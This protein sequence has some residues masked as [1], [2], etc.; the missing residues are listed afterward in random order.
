[1][2]RYFCTV[3]T[4]LLLALVSTGSAAAGLPLLGDTQ[5]GSQ[6]TSF[7]DQ[8]VGEQKNDADVN[9]A[10][11][12]G[13]V[14]VSPAIAIFGDA[15]TWNAQGNGNT[16]Q[17]DVD[18]SNT[19]TQTQDSR[20][21]QDL[22]QNGPSGS[23]HCCGGQSQTGEQATDFGDQTVDKQK[24]T[25]TSTRHRERERERLPGNRGVR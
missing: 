14:N 11:G 7:G 17:A 5:Q 20:Q 19:A 1:M 25:P 23:G 24:T 9:Q 4:G 10:Q 8:S 12:N 22:E 2:K 16:A 3:A 21:N 15:T 13:N 6:S 18:Q